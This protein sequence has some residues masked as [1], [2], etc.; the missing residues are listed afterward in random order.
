[1]MRSTCLLAVILSG[2]TVPEDPATSAV[3][4]EI[5]QCDQLPFMC[6]NSPGTLFYG[7]HELSLLG[8]P[9]AQNAKI[10]PGVLGK[11]ELRKGTSRYRLAVVG[12]EIKGLDPL[13]GVTLLRGDS[14]VGA[15]LSIIDATTGAV[16][17]VM[18][19]DSHREGAYPYPIRSTDPLHM[20]VISRHA[21]GAPADPKLNVCNTYKFPPQPDR[22]GHL[23]GMA[24][25]EVLLF[26]GERVDVTAK[27][28]SPNPADATGWITFGC[29]GHALAKLDLSNNTRHREPDPAAWAG[30][31]AT[32][33]LYVADYCGGGQPFTV[34]MTPLLWKGGAIT[35]YVAAPSGL[36]AR[37]SETGAICLGT[38]R[39]AAHPEEGDPFYDEGGVLEAI[40]KQCVL[41][42]HALPTCPNLDVENLDGAP[43]ISANYFPLPPM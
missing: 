1:M 33:K 3:E 16:L 28:L 12:G 10:M 36:E 40:R 35:E 29:A 17:Y 11:P 30:H 31:Q 7:I 43:R 41:N 23:M 26:D 14:V 39:L 22:G 19:I 34:P 27:T 6:N 37:W 2:C 24:E 20:Y 5:N 4:S 15:E 42:G 32:L 8:T 13:W 21:P 9:N 18:Q 38:A 25:G